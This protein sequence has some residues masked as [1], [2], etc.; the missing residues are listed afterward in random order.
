MVYI[1]KIPPGFD[2]EELRRAMDYVREELQ[3]LSSSLVETT[4]LELRTTNQ[5]PL[6]PRNGMIVAA[7]GTNWNPGAGAGTYI[8]Q[9]GTW[10]KLG[11][12]SHTHVL[13]DITNAGSLAALNELPLADMADLATQRVIG[14]NT[15]STGIPEAVTLSQLL[16]WIGSAARGDVLVRGA[17]SWSR[18]AIG[19]AGKYLG[20]DGT[21]PSWTS[22]PA[23]VWTVVP[24]LS[25]ETLTTNTTLQDDNELFFPVEANKI[26][27][28]Q[29]QI[30][31][32]TPLAADFKFT[33][34][35]PASPTLVRYGNIGYAI[36]KT[37][38]GTVIVNASSDV[39]LGVTTLLLLQ[40]GNNAGTVQF[41]W[42]Q[43]SSSGTTTV[44][45][46]SIL[47]YMKLN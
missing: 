8:Y 16:D 41:Q 24:K 12:A 46:G 44:Y 19:S 11:N 7:D 37:V 23:P 43:N 1:P 18:L 36:H 45:A 22:F 38:F 25:N 13:T 3:A 20:T 28:A 15:G 30:F 39:N 33:F 6:K 26:Y 4:S 2:N 14:R 27:V 9:S 40:N 34:T 42:A 31:L 17:S 10:V 29:L 35:G 32:N 47:S 21:D 5:A